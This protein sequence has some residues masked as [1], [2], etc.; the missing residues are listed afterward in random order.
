MNSSLPSKPLHI[1]V[2][3]DN[4]G[5]FLLLEESIHMSEIPVADI[6]QADTL[7]AAIGLLTQIKPDIIFLD[8]FLSD[9]SGLD[10]FQQLQEYMTHSAVIIL[11][12]LSDTKVAQEAIAGGAQDFLAKGE[13]DDRTRPGG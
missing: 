3:E 8:L 13:F 10:S 11:S 6:Q 1:L 9:S 12:G 7:A 2:I 4:P 5:D